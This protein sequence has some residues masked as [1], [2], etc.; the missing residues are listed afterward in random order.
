MSPSTPRWRSSSNYDYVDKLTAPDIGWEWLRRNED[1]QRDYADLIASP[2]P[3]ERVGKRWGL[4]F[5]CRSSSQ[6][7][8]GTGVLASGRRNRIGYTGAGAATLRRR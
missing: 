7:D 8:R 1:Y 6:I 4:R 5:P 3:I 2:S